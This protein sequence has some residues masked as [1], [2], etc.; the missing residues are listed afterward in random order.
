LLTTAGFQVPVIPFIEVVG[1][2]G[3]VAPL[4]NAGIAAKVGVIEGFTVTLKEVVLAQSPTVGVNVYVALAALLTVAGLQV[5]VIPLVDVVANIGAVVP[6]HIGAIAAKVGV[7]T[8]FTVTFKVAV[9]A[10]SP[11]VGVKV[12]VPLAV[13]LTVAGLQVPVIPLVDVVGK[14]G[15]VA[16]LQIAGMAT[17]VGV[18]IGFTVTVKLAVAIQL[19]ELAVNT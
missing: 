7:V 6:L 2:T 11:T 19:P 12:Y 3:A 18:T 8:A 13:L 9:L 16:P 5:P 17:N 14:T 1:K 10:Q 4:H 15:A